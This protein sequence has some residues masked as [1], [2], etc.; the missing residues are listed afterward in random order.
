MSTNPTGWPAPVSSHSD[1]KSATVKRAKPK[2]IELL[3]NG[4]NVSSTRSKMTMEYIGY[5]WN[6][7]EPFFGSKA[8]NYPELAYPRAAGFFDLRSDLDSELLNKIKGQKVNLAQ[9]LVEH[10]QTAQLFVDVAG[11][12]LRAGRALAAG[13]PYGVL[14]ALVGSDKSRWPANWKEMV[15]EPRKNIANSTLAWNFGISPLLSD[16]DGSIAEL[17]EA[18]QTKPLYQKFVVKRVFTDEAYKTWTNLSGSQTYYNATGRSSAQKH[19]RVVCYVEFDKDTLVRDASR[20]GFMNVPYLLWEAVP[21][22]WAV[23]YVLNI[24]QFLSNLDALVGVKR[25]AKHT[26]TVEVLTSSTTYTAPR[27]NGV[28]GTGSDSTRHSNRSFSDRVNNVQIHWAQPP[29]FKRVLNLL[30]VSSNLSRKSFKL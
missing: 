13:R 20:L 10:K 24:G 12:V 23:D 17:V 30:A 21:Y 18:Y 16:L 5:Y 28:G 2:G 7:N 26:S 15:R 14:T 4:S 19:I 3:F 22:S 6:E 9:M 1:I 29:A 11:R 8:Q 25:L 27:I